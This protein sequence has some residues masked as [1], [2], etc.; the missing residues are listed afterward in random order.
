MDNPIKLM[1]VFALFILIATS[2]CVGVAGER[3]TSILSVAA[4]D[5][6]EQ[7][8]SDFPFHFFFFF[9]CLI[10]S[11]PCTIE[12]W[13]HQRGRGNCSTVCC[14]VVS[15][16]QTYAFPLLL[17]IYILCKQILLQ[18][19]T[20]CAL[21]LSR[22]EAYL[23]LK[24][25]ICWRQHVPFCAREIE[26]ERARVM[27][28]EGAKRSSLSLGDPGLLSLCVTPRARRARSWLETVGEP[29]APPAVRDWD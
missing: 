22:Q 8:A 12:S 5:L 23:S 25:S 16:R 9:C 27:L 17:L 24:V 15:L 28:P 1:S 26:Q 10:Y 21:Y 11:I 4:G 29:A 6:S 19:N 14:F 2:D 7:G 13:I 18:Y 3:A 20:M